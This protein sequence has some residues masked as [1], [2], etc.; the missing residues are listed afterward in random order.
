MKYVRIIRISGSYF[1]REF[2]RDRDSSKK[3]QYREVD[4]GTVADQFQK[5]D[6]SVEVIFEDSDRSS[7]LLDPESDP[8]L[9]KKYLGRR[10]LL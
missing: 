10:F 7:I 1:A 9:I 2:E 8:E 4:E 3:K 6:A 5:G